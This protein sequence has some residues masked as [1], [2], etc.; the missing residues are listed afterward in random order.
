M[1]LSKNQVSALAIHIMKE[2][3][4]PI[5]KENNKISELAKEEWE[6]GHIYNTVMSLVPE[7]MTGSHYL[8]HFLNELRSHCC[9]PV[10]KI[11][12]FSKEDVER[13]IYVASIGADADS[14]IEKIKSLLAREYEQIKAAG[15]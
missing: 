12:L 15:N 8:K 2:V 10:K 14:I 11:P 1:N 4:D 9:E 7:K 6:R 3:N 5:V 13:K